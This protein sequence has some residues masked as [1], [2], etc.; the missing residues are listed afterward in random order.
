[1]FVKRWPVV[2]DAGSALDQHIVFKEGWKDKTP[3][4]QR[5]IY[6]MLININNQ[7]YINVLATSAWTT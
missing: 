1:M 7:L 6:E 5:D 3:A 2:C 4:A